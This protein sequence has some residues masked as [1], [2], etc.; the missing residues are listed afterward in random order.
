MKQ[1]RQNNFKEKCK[2]FFIYSI[3]LTPIM[4][5][6]LLAQNNSQDNKNTWLSS[7]PDDIKQ[8]IIWSANHEKGDLSDWEMGGG[9]NSGGGIF[10]TGLKNE[11]SA[12]IVKENAFSGNFSVKTSI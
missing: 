8:S 5:I 7:L 12:N 1:I 10:N 2:L 11:A 3:F 4:I 6:P 9:K